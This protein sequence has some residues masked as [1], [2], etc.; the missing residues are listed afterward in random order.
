MHSPATHRRAT[1]TSSSRTHA[2]L[3]WLGEAT[4]LVATIHADDKVEICELARKA[5]PEAGAAELARIVEAVGDCQPLLVLAR[6]SD[7]LALEREFVF[8]GGQP[9]RLVDVA[10]EPSPSRDRLVARV[11]ETDRHPAT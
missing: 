7:R 2:A 8:L 4:A 3:A 9:D 11:R 5:D 10:W 1:A 6:D